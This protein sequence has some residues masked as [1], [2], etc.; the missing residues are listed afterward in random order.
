[1]KKIIPFAIFF[2]IINCK[3]C[4]AQF[5]GQY[6]SDNHIYSASLS[7]TLNL[8]KSKDINLS[9][10]NGLNTNI[11]LKTIHLAYSYNSKL[12]LK[13]SFHFKGKKPEVE[14][15][16]LS[17]K[18]GT[19]GIGYYRFINKKESENYASG[20]EFNVF[21]DYSFYKMDKQF[22]NYGF[23]NHQRLKYMIIKMDKL[24]VTG[25]V[26]YSSQK[27]FNINY[28]ASIGLLNFNKISVPFETNTGFIPVIDHLKKNQFKPILEQNLVL[29]LGGPILR[30]FISYSNVLSLYKAKE[31]TIAFREIAN[32]DILTAGLI[33]EINKIRDL[34][35]K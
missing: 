34:I 7:N 29:H 16:T 19:V 31:E 20:L 9:I 4:S 14:N 21:V 2:L 11:K 32:N 18:I 30:Y 8:K 27:I 24:A 1:M 15:L 23:T 10:S 6:Y 28:Q 33:F 26:N 25:G 3:I 17:P 35:N 12:G 5:Q 22:V 13:A